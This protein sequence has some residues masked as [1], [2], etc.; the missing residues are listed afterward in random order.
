MFSHTCVRYMATTQN[1]DL[2]GERTVVAH[3]GAQAPING[4]QCIRG[5]HGSFVPD[6]DAASR[7]ACASSDWPLRCSTDAELSSSGVLNVLCAVAPLGNNMA[8][9]P[10]H[11][12]HTTV[13]CMRFIVLTITF[14]TNVF[15]VPPGPSTKK[16]PPPSRDTTAFTTSLWI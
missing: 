16:Q 1:D 9:I 2:S 4:I 5:G 8:A 14:Y 11:A 12:T 15:P 3:Q 6:D 7:K 13:R 10:V